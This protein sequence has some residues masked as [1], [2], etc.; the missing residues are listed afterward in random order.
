MVLL[1]CPVNTVGNQQTEKS[2]DP[3][4]NLVFE[5]LNTDNFR[6]KHNIW[7]DKSQVDVVLIISF[8]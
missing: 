2:I 6:L 1:N 5:R 8:F 3:N 7:L 4:E